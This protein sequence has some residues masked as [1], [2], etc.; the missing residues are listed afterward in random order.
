MREIRVFTPEADNSPETLA[1]RLQDL[2]FHELKMEYPKEKLPEKCNDW[3]VTMVYEHGDTYSGN[4]LPII[5]VNYFDG[6]N[7]FQSFCL[8]EDDIYNV[9]Q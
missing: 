2:I 6:D 8:I 4:L 3:V 9:G 1:R 7:N 5:Y